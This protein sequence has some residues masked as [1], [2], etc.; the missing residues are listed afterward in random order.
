MQSYISIKSL[1]SLRDKLLLWK[2]VY[3]RN[4]LLPII[5][6]NLKRPIRYCSFRLI[7]GT[8]V[9]TLQKLSM[10]IPAGVVQLSISVTTNNSREY[11]LSRIYISDCP[12]RAFYAYIKVILLI[13]ITAFYGNT[14]ILEGDI[15]FPIGREYRKKIRAHLDLVG[16]KSRL[17]I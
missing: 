1:N 3:W 13:H 7:A 6:P 10:L 8:Y 11:A 5:L 14:F 2:N 4:Y 9:S 17:Y 12:V 15:E 16:S